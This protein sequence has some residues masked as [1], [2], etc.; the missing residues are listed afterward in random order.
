MGLVPTVVVRVPRRGDVVGRRF[1]VAGIGEG[2]EGTL[3]VE[4]R[5]E[6]RVVARA[7]AQ[8]RAGGVGA[9]DYAVEVELEERVRGGTQLVVQV[10]SSTGQGQP[11]PER[12]DRTRV[13]CFPRATGFVVHEVDPGDTLTGILRGL[14]DLTSADVADVVAANRQVEDPDVIE[15]GWRLTIPLLPAGP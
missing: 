3:D 14:G 9:G 2:F 10:A 7:F 13:V 12:T 5:D 8:T 6:D 1:L 4:V 11:G 15:V